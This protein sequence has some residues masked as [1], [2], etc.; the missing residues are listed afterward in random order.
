[1]VSKTAIVLRSIMPQGGASG[2]R[3]REIRTKALD[4]NELKKL[5][6]EA[7]K[8]PSTATLKKQAKKSA[9]KDK[10]DARAAERET[11]RL[12]N[13]ETP[14]KHKSVFKREAM[15]KEEYFPEEQGQ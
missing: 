4:R 14:A 12:N 1:M 13:D 7:N 5:E 8:A 15:I 2:T 6:A 9:K 10:A 3:G 11:R